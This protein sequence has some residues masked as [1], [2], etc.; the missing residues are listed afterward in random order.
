MFLQQL[1][2]QVLAVLNYFQQTC[3]LDSALGFYAL[4]NQNYLDCYQSKHNPALGLEL[5]EVLGSV[6]IQKGVV[7]V[8][9]LL[10]LPTEDSLLWVAL[11]AVL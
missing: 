4:L 2:N 5:R 6:R 7:I 1:E 11:E 10:Y 8:P 3:P 9:N